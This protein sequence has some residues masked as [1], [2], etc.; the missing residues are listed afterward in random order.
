MTMRT[1]FIPPALGLLL[2]A[3]PAVAQTPGQRIIMEQTGASR[4]EGWVRIQSTLNFFVAGPTGESEEAQKLRDRARRAVYEMAARECDL[5]RE[6]IAKDCRM[7]G[8]VTAGSKLAGLAP[9][10]MANMK[11][12]IEQ[13]AQ[14]EPDI[15]KIREGIR[16]CQ[17]SD[18][19]REGLAALRERRPP[20][21]KGR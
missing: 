21:F 9:L 10:S 6:V 8:L 18:D 3:V 17:T 11:R 12:A 1:R 20:A 2:L 5:L 16:E 15:P 14:A 19:L 4:Q 7:K 13:F